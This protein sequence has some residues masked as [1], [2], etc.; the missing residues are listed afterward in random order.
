MARYQNI[1][2]CVDGSEESLHALQEA[3]K[4]T[5]SR[6]LAAVSVAPP[7]EGDLRVMGGEQLKTLMREPCDTALG[8]SQ[9][10]ADKAGKAIKTAC[11]IGTPHDG[12]VDFAE[13]ENCDLIVMGAKGHGFLERVLLGSV[14]RRVIGFTKRDVLV[15]P[16][17]A[18]LGWKKVMLATDGSE[19]SQP[20]GNRA[21]E[22]AQ[23]YGAELTVLSILELPSRL[24]GNVREVLAELIKDREGM[25]AEVRAQA[26]ALGIK[27]QC[28]TSQGYPARTIVAEAQKQG[29]NLIVM[30]SHGRT[31]LTRLLM[32]SVTERVIGMAPCPVLVVKV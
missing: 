32:G 9:E 24:G 4:L 8:K 27:T 23:A 26:E 19:N 3:L 18:D 14:T 17:H 22:L 13:S 6:G 12:I 31:G 10:M 2:V 25:L 5:D 21:L 28:F 7:Y 29:V 20:A 11:V 30:G 16:P 1:L 15:I